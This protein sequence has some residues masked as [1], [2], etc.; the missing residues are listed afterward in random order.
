MIND[1]LKIVGRLDIVLRDSNGNIKETRNIPNLVVA[2]GKN[3]IAAR[4]IGNTPSVMTHMAVGADNGTI[5][6]VATSNTALGAQLDSRVVLTAVSVLN[7]VVTYN[8]EF[9]IGE[10][11]GAITEAGIFN[12]ATAGSM[13]CRTTFPVINKEESDI[14]T[15]N[16]N[17][18]VS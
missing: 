16:W 7:N 14:L 8:A 10:S 4:L 12:D 6:P 15:I 1:T 18:T 5:L 13:L 9:D 17:V 11:T 2:A 3:V